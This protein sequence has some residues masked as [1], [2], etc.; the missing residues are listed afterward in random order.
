MINC[1]GTSSINQS[2]FKQPIADPNTEDSVNLRLWWSKKSE[3]DAMKQQRLAKK[4]KITTQIQHAF[5][6]EAIGKYVPLNGQK[7]HCFVLR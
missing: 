1:K 2:A 6:K 5:S 4:V 7:L 3:K